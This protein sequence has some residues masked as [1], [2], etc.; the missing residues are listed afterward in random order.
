[1]ETGVDYLFLWRDRNVV[2]DELS[3]DCEEM[4]DRS[5][6]VSLSVHKLTYQP[7]LN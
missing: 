6:Q 2:V 7:V 5:S 4:G 1:M 3:H